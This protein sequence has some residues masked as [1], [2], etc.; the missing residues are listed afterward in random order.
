M[1]TKLNKP[2]ALYTARATSAVID[3]MCGIDENVVEEV[4]VKGGDMTLVVRN[5]SVFRAALAD[6]IASGVVK[7]YTTQ[8]PR[9][10]G[11]RSHSNRGTF[12]HTDACPDKPATSWPTDDDE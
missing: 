2:F 3:A 6:L 11:S 10:G 1:K 12:L 4:K 5:E 8:C 7:K 9:C